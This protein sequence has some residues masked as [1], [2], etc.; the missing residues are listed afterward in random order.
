MSLILWPIADLMADC[1][2]ALSTGRLHVMLDSDVYLDNR[3]LRHMIL[4]NVS[5][6]PHTGLSLPPI[7]SLLL[8]PTLT[9][10]S[11]S[12]PSTGLLGSG[13]LSL[14]LGFSAKGLST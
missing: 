12:L 13:G 9:G 3:M 8:P 5:S 10:V 6:S 2:V 7:Q 14:N 4:H 11:I 1:R